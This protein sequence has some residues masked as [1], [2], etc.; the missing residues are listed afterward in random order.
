[1]AIGN[2][3]NRELREFYSQGCLLTLGKLSLVKGWLPRG[4]VTSRG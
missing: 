2:K 4:Q 3:V 1:M